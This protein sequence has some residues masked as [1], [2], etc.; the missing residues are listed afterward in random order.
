[1]SVFVFVCFEGEHFKINPS[2]IAYIEAR[3]NYSRVF[4]MHQ[5]SYLVLVPLK[6]RMDVLSDKEFAVVH[7]GYIAA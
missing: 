2:V 7:R 1:V 4:C 3:K 5:E 6:A